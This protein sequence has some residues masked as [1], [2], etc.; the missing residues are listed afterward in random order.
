VA[1]HLGRLHDV[2]VLFSAY[3]EVVDDA[4][5]R[6]SVR[7]K[8][9]PGIPGGRSL[10]LGKRLSLCRMGPKAPRVLSMVR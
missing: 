7:E 2:H 5:R 3:D 4:V 6:Q 8:L 1:T 10:Q 9:M